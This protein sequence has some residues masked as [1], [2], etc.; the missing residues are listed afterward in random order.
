MLRSNVQSSWKSELY[1]AAAA[2]LPFLACAN[3]NIVMGGGCVC[4]GGRGMSINCCQGHYTRLG[5]TAGRALALAAGK[6][7]LDV[8][9]PERGLGLVTSHQ[10]R[11]P[12]A[13]T[14]LDITLSLARFVFSKRRK[15]IWIYSLVVICQETKNKTALSTTST[16]HSLTNIQLY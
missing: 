8:M 7:A 16:T 13:H 9:E 1:A 3:F 12:P 14:A 2:S 4:G 5:T 15:V 11:P 10:W 6:C